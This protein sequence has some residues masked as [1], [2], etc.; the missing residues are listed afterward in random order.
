MRSSIQ[1]P[2]QKKHFR[3]CDSAVLPHRG[4]DEAEDFEYQLYLYLG[5][6]AQENVPRYSNG[7]SVFD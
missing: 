3:K 2:A 1:P 5:G 6:V 7:F 4:R